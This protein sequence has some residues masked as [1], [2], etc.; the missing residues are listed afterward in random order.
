EPFLVDDRYMPL[1]EDFSFNSIDDP[2]FYIGHFKAIRQNGNR[3][4]VNTTHGAVYRIDREKIIKIAQIDLKGYE[5]IAGQNLFIDDKDNNQLLFFGE[6]QRLADGE[7]FPQME[8]LTNKK[9][10]SKRFGAL[11]E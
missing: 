4:I 1:A 5:G 6:V 3:Y 10:I 11:F 2:L 9:Q 7:G 8:V